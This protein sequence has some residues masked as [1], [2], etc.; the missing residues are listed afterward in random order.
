MRNSIG[1]GAASTGTDGTPRD[2]R[3]V[4][5]RCMNDVVLLAPL[6]LL[7]ALTS[8]DAADHAAAPPPPCVAC[9]H[10]GT[11]APRY[12]ADER[13]A[14]DA[15]EVVVSDAT[16]ESSGDARATVRAAAIIHQP[17]ALVW[18]TLI[19][20][21]ARA[22]WQADTK[23]ARV[24]RADRDRVWV[25]QHVRLFL[26]DIRFT[27]INTLDPERG[28]LSWV[29]DDSAEHDIANTTGSWRL[30]PLAD[31]R[32]TLL[33]YQAA[34]DS[35][36]AVPGFVERYLTKRSLPNLLGTLRAEVERRAHVR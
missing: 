24:V 13:A 7:I 12:S 36:R 29:L 31:G 26:V 8:A 22:R 19:D 15:G 35:G 16:A 5:G 23:E 18:Q 28:V 21:P 14:L 34:V 27:V 20:F 25:A 32:S 4:S 3:I 6:A 9:R 2:S 10:D 11:S 30:T 33:T 1:A 17:P